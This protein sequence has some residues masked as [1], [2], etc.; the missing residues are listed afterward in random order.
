[1][2][3]PRRLG[4]KLIDSIHSGQIHQFGGSPGVRDAG[5]I[6]SA[7]ARPVNKWE[8]GQE[9]DLCALA[10]AYAYGLTTNHGYIDGNKRIG[11]LAMYVFLGLNGLELDT[12]EPEAVRIMLKVAEGVCEEPELTEWVRSW[13]EA[14]ARET[15]DADR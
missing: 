13:T 12:P 15:E 3:E 4:R 6:E 8:Y 11:F 1:V 7:L 14:P 9:R 2:K 10:A 5:L